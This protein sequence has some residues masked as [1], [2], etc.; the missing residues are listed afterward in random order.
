[1]ASA[2]RNEGENV[3]HHVTQHATGDEPFFRDRAD[4]SRFLWT[5][6]R[7][8][9]RFDWEILAFCLMMT[10][11][12]FVVRT[13]EP[14]LG[15]GM[16]YLFAWYCRW[17]NERHGRRGHLVASV[18]YAGLI[19]TEAHRLATLAYIALNPVNAG[20]CK[21][22]EDYRWSSYAI[23]TGIAPPP[24]PAVRRLVADAQRRPVRGREAWPVLRGPVTPGSAA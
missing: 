15:R 24:E 13:R 9:Q 23:R 4:R 11:V 16:Q 17:F 8:M 22:A 21:D 14:N 20:V 12:H 2:P 10:H 1:M 19:E 18:Y 7:T 6:E 3:L 5:T